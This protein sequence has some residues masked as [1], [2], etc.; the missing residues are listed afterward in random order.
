MDK[1]HAKYNNYPII[2]LPY[3]KSNILFKLKG[4]LCEDIIICN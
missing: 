3:I 4:R 2:L 1:K